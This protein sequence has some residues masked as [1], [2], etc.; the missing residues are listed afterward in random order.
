MAKT[1]PKL[2][3]VVDNTKNPPGPHRPAGAAAI[4]PITITQAVG[5]RAA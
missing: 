1:N 2:Y 3:L 4:S 5:L